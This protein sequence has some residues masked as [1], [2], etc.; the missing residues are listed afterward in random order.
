MF[1]ALGS[2]RCYKEAWP[3][4]DILDLFKDQKSKQFDPELTDLFLNDM[5]DFLEIRDSHGVDH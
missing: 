2:K 1:D 4:E 3:L 5:D